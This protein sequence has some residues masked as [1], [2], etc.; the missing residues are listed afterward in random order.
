MLD[1][2]EQTHQLPRLS[3]EHYGGT[4]VLIT[5]GACDAVQLAVPARNVSHMALPPSHPERLPAP[6]CQESSVNQWEAE[7][8]GAVGR[9]KR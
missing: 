3:F 4:A 8:S 7:E 6:A 9:F 2:A 5:F 1:S